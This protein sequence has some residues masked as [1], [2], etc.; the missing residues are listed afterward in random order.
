[1][2]LC[3]EVTTSQ[4]DNLSS[5]QEAVCFGWLLASGY[6]H[7]FVSMLEW[8]MGGRRL[9]YNLGLIMPLTIGKP[10]P[11]F[12]LPDE[13]GKLHS[14][15]DYRGKT[16]VLYF[17]PADD[18]PGCTKEACNFRDDYLK[19]LAAGAVILGVSPDD[20][21]SHQKFKKKY[22]LPFPLLADKGHK[23]CELYGVWGEKVTFGK[24]YTGVIRST[25]IIN[26][27]G[28]LATVFDKVRVQEHSQAV[29]SALNELKTA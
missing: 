23:V 18:T 16:V 24:H 29:L 2:V 25:F 4:Y 17:Y 14:L 5:N 3:L 21:D 20:E 27:E 13:T 19:Y 7:S 15:S 28:R 10:A 6:Q 12:T 1:M 9:A 8:V 26:P 22:K 11:A